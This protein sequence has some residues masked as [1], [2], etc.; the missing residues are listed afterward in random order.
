M[1]G[2]L[3][4]WRHKMSATASWCDVTKWRPPP[5]GV[6]SQNDGHCLMVWCHKIAATASWCDVTKWR[7]SP[8]GVTSQNGGHRLEVWRHKMKAM[9]SR[10][11][12]T[13]WR[14]PVPW[15]HYCTHYTMY[16]Y[17]TAILAYHKRKSRVTVLC[18]FCLFV[19]LKNFS[20]TSVN[21][22]VLRAPYADKYLNSSLWPP[23]GKGCYANFFWSLLPVF[24][25]PCDFWNYLHDDIFS[26]IRLLI[27]S[28]GNF[29]CIHNCVQP[30][31]PPPKSRFPK[32]PNPDSPSPP[33][34]LR[35]KC[36][37]LSMWTH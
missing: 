9:A 32:T 34:V 3:V 26:S 1:T 22:S 17:I 7:P 36:R 5:R 6:T 2:S 31:P 4:V 27:I 21:N 37:S 8:R 35:Q 20:W 11:D 24:F 25:P 23:R 29:L 18:S 15:S 30:P 19:Q 14:P 16:M 13:K 33:V 10:C 28:K 12:V